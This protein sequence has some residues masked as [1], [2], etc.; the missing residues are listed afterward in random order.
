MARRQVISC[1]WQDEQGNALALGTIVFEASGDAL[2]TGTGELCAGI[3]GSLTLDNTGSVASSPAQYMWPTDQMSP[4]NI[5]YT[6]W[7]YSANGQLAWGPNYGLTVPS[8]AGSFNLCTW[9]P[10][11]IGSSSGAAAG[12][13]T[14][15][16]N[17][18]NNAVQSLLDLVNGANISI[19]DNGNGSVTIS[20]S[21]SGPRKRNWKGWTTAGEDTLA[22]TQG[23]GCVPSTAGTNT[24][25]APTATTPA[26]FQVGSGASPGL[27]Y[28]DVNASTHTAGASFTLGILGLSEIQ[29]GLAS[30]ANIRAWI[31]MMN[32]IE[33]GANFWESDTPPEPT[34]AFRYSTHA[35][36]TNFQCVVTDGTTQVSA[37]SGVVADTALHVFGIEVSGTNI[38]FFIDGTQVA[39]VSTSTTTLSTS[40]H[41]SPA[42]TVDNVGLSN[43]KAVNVTYFY[44]DT[45]V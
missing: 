35:S 41:F 31:G 37:D 23:Y 28:L 17:G 8:G 34:I 33:G 5:T 14:L 20:S 10:N 6:V 9:V 40:S 7:V 42:F 32:D 24:G 43:N 21:G 30:T 36:D 38:L 15:Q 27:A 16:V 44:W 39:S 26:L 45:T 25:I 12:S 29:C 11:Q 22:P 19:V 1:P 4:S 3:K 2:V 18:V 13:L